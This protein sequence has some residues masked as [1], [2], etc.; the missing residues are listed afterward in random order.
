[1]RLFDVLPLV[2][3][4]GSELDTGELVTYLNDAILL[5][6]SPA[7]SSSVPTIHTSS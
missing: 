1:M 3:A 6:P 4:T 7:M 2:D 5:A